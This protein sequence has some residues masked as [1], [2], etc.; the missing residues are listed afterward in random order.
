MHRVLV[1]HGTQLGT[2]V[3]HPMCLSSRADVVE[4]RGSD[5]LHPSAPIM[6]RNNS[7][8]LAGLA[9]RAHEDLDPFAWKELAVSN[10]GCRPCSEHQQYAKLL[11][12]QALRNV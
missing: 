3:G 2:A 6:G 5:P 12:E 1:E 7:K 11:L 4:T 9:K 10:M 8:P